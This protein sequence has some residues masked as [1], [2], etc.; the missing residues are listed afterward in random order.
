MLGVLFIKL[1]ICNS[2]QLFLVLLLLLVLPMLSVFV[3]SVLLLLLC[4]L[5]IEFDVKSPVLC[6]VEIFLFLN[7]YFLLYYTMCLCVLSVA[8][9]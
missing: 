4:A 2:I 9:H 5:A 3:L 1:F 7:I 8:R 6:V